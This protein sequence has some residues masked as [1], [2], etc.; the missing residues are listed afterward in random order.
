MAL[1]LSL[2]LLTAG[3]LLGAGLTWLLLREELGAAAG[4]ELP[5]LPTLNVAPRPLRAPELDPLLAE[6][7]G[8]PES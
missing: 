4:E 7:T 1:V 5:A 6:Q 2:A 3:S 8:L